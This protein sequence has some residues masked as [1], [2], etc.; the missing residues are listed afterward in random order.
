MCALAL[1]ALLL[2]ISCVIAIYFVGDESYY[3][4]YTFLKTEDN[5]Q[6]SHKSLRKR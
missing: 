4:T 3:L 2:L 1:D 5:F 6:Y